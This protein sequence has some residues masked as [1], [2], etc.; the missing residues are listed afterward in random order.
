MN[1]FTLLIT[2]CLLAGIVK[3]VVGFGLPIIVV[4]LVS[5]LHSHALALV[6]IVLPGVITNAWQAW[7][8]PERWMLLRRLAPLLVVATVGIL[9]ATRFSV[10]ID[11]RWLR[12]L[13][14]AIIII[15]AIDSLRRPNARPL[16]PSTLYT[17]ACGLANG[18][19]TGLTGAFAFPGIAW[20][21]RLGLNAEQTVQAMGILFLVSAIV[22]GLSLGRWHD[23]DPSLWLLSAAGV[24]AALIGMAIGRRLRQRLNEAQFRRVLLLA[25]LGLGGWLV[26]QPWLG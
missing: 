21:R 9:L 26:L 17:L 14:G 11:E 18:V 7:A 6:A 16:P 12:G 25:L 22:L 5:A 20:I 13:L 10:G 2:A 1:S 24:P 3:G 4:G 19:L 15:W 8:G 23:V